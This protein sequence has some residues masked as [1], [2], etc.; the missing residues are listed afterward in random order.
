MSGNHC[1]FLK[2][3]DRTDTNYFFNK[4]LTSQAFT[5]K[6]VLKG[7]LSYLYES[8]KNGLIVR[9]MDI[10]FDYFKRSSEFIPGDDTIVRVNIH[11]LRSLLDAYYLEEGKKDSIV[12]EIPKGSYSLKF[13]RKSQATGKNIRKRTRNKLLYAVLIISFLVNIFL[14]FRSDLFSKD[15]RN[16]VWKDYIESNKPVY[17]TLGD[18]FFFRVNDSIPESVIVRDITVNSPDELNGNKSYNISKENSKL[19]NL[20]YPYFSTSNVWPLPALIS[21][22]ARTNTDIRLQALSEMKAEDM[23]RNN[24]IF[25]ANI[26]SFGYINK[27]LEQTSIRLH[28]NPRHII[29][30]KGKDSMVFSVPEF[31][32]GYYMDYAFLVKIPGPQKN[33]ITIMGDFHGSGIKGLTNYITSQS[34]MIELET[35]VKRE[36]GKFPE[37]FEIVAKVVS[38]DY[39]D[40]KTEIIYF[41][42]INN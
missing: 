2:K 24:S 5:N 41:K 31:V 27:F 4:I 20:T 16:P 26:N 11:K 40:F 19:S 22:F 38:Y 33:I 36:Y 12:L 10:A 21:V 17:I 37:Y 9:E 15:Y 3:M 30:G 6:E 39:A 35:K 13:V 32:H 14:L 28:T 18:P 34:S 23:K 7:L 42:P 29:V 25:I 1:V 8:S